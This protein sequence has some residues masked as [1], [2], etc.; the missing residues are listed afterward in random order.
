MWEVTKPI[1]ILAIG[2]SFSV[3]SMEYLWNIANNYGYS[4]VILGNLYIGGCSV[5]THYFNSLGDHKNYIYYKNIT[6]EWVSKENTSLLEGLLDE[7]WDI[8]TMQQASGKSGVASTYEPFVSELIKYVEKYQPQA[9]LMWNMTWAYQNDSQHGEFVN[10]DHSQLKMYKA[11]VKTV[12]KLII[13]NNKFK[14]IIPVGTAIQNIRTSSVGD[15]L[16]RDGFH[17]SLGLGRYVAGL[18]WF[19]TIFNAPIDSIDYYPEGVSLEEAKLAKQ[20]VNNAANNPFKV[21]KL[22]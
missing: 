6:G 3:D 14:M 4:N 19:K 15:F 22:F 12:K 16:T 2:N 18:T 13:N 7:K 10:Y 9:T 5:E 1:K 11:I 20:A 8:I 21:T 17:L